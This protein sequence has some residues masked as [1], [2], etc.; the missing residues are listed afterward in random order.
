MT[1]EIINI[2]G[3]VVAKEVFSKIEN[4]LNIQF[5]VSQLPVG[6]YIIQISEQDHN[7]TIDQISKR[8]IIQR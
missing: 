8:F 3:Q 6:N 2:L 7:A 4:Q 5:D 1:I